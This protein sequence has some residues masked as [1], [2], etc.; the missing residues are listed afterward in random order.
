MSTNTISWNE[1]I[2]RRHTNAVAGNAAA[3]NAPPRTAPEEE[4]K[5]TSIAQNEKEQDDEDYIESI[6]GEATRYDPYPYP[7]T[8]QTIVCQVLRSEGVS[9]S[10]K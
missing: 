1:V 2:R 5:E 6:S 9:Y 7:G 10:S 3:D 8:N 4:V